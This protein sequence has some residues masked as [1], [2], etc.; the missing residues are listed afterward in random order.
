MR[1]PRAERRHYAWAGALLL[2]AACAPGN[3]PAPAAMS[4]RDSAGITI[5]ENEVAPDTA[6]TLTEELRIGALDTEGPELLTD[7]I[8]VLPTPRGDIVVANGGSVSARVFDPDGRFLREF[9]ARGEGP[10]ELNWL[11]AMRVVGDTVLLIDWQGVGKVVR[12]TTGGDFVTSLTMRQPDGHTLQPTA[13]DG[14]SWL[15][16]YTPPHE[17]RV[18]EF[19]E[20]RDRVHTVHRYDWGT[21][22]LGP[23]VYSRVAHSVYGTESG[24]STADSGHFTR[25]MAETPFDGSGRWYI[26]SPRDYEVQVMGPDGLERIVR[27]TIERIPV[28]AEAIAAIRDAAISVIDTMTGLSPDRRREQAERLGERLDVRGRLPYPPFVPPIRAILAGPAGDIWVAR[29]DGPDF[30]TVEGG[31]LFRGL[32]NLPTAPIVWDVFGADGRLRGSVT[33]PAFVRL[34]AVSGNQAWGVAIDDF[35]VPYVVRFQL[36]AAP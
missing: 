19:G 16:N 13:H 11:N 8:K 20:A 9:G 24:T 7:V 32:S 26:A 12:F 6:F 15:A 22:E 18:L 17:P 1:R 29:A 35:D 34:D 36:E 25:F 30:A 5:V 2:A 10:A 33:T 14:A 21:A 28:D 23:R 4:V 3:D 31:A 27:R